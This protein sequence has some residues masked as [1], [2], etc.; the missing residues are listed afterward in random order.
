[1]SVTRRRSIRGVG[2][3]DCELP[4]GTVGVIPS[5]MTD[6]VVCSQFTSGEPRVSISALVQLRTVLDRVVAG[7]PQDDRE[8]VRDHFLKKRAAAATLGHDSAK[9]APHPASTRVALEDDGRPAT[10]NST[11]VDNRVGDT[12]A[13]CRYEP[14]NYQKQ[15]E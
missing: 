15:G 7:D 10:R 12:A 4:D 3:I 1:M 11:R 14:N 8:D 2:F 9:K 13:N 6:A 5:W